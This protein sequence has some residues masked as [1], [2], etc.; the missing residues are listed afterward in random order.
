MTKIYFLILFLVS[1]VFSKEKIGIAGML[2]GANWKGM[3]LDDE[4]QNIGGFSLGLD[5]RYEYGQHFH[6]GIGTL[7]SKEWSL[8][9]TG[10]TPD[11]TI[12]LNLI[13]NG[14]HVKYWKFKIDAGF[15][16]GFSYKTGPGK[17]I[18]IDKPETNER[19]LIMCFNEDIPT[20]QKTIFDPIYGFYWNLLFDFDN[21]SFGWKFR[22]LRDRGV[23]FLN[24]SVF[25]E[26][27]LDL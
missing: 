10:Y 4:F 24:P 21:I 1:I 20:E 16:V 18:A 19:C 8:F 15:S 7:T 11:N 6:A 2:G 17:R 25:F 9:R 22:N 5:I 3:A 13:E 27:K 26:I 14:T 23:W 12:W